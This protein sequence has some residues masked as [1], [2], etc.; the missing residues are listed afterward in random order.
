MVIIKDDNLPAGQ[1][2]LGRINNIYPGKD[3]KRHCYWVS[4]ADKR[5]RVY[6][7]L[8]PRPDAVAQYSGGAPVTPHKSLNS[9]RYFISEPDLLT[10]P[11]AKILEEFSDQGVI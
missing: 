9:S 4:A 8:D 10:T 3:S 7:A 11:E 1:W 2:S 6:Y 5:L